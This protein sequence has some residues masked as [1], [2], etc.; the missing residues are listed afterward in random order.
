MATKTPSGPRVAAIVGPYLCG[1]TAL[2]ESILALTGAV[3]RKGSS[4]EGY[5]VG[6]TTPEAKKRQM[7]TEVNIAST[8]YIGEPW[9]FLDCPGSVE[10]IQDSLNALMVADTAI[11]VCEPDTAR[12]LTVAPILNFLDENDIP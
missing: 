2:F 8:E 5:A 3:G 6:D 4:K 10:L 12:A 7:S 11:V 1:K 9:T